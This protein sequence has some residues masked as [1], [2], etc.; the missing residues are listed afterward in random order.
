MR[1]LLICGLVLATIACGGGGDSGSGSPTNPEPTA[2]DFLIGTWVGT[3]E[4]T[5]FNVS[6]TL[7]ATMTVNGNMVEATGKIGLQ[8][9]GLGEETGTGVGTIDGNTLSFTFD[10]STVGNGEGEVAGDEGSGMGT[11]LGALNFGDFTFEG[12]VGK[13][14]ITGEFEFTAPSGGRG[15][16]SLTKQ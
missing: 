4:D 1:C 11:V 15:V 12:A 10:A 6:G 2:F 3:W 8:S 9:L 14:M 13:T 7:E 16:A 5:R